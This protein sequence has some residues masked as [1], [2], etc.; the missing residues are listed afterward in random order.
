MAWTRSK[1]AIALYVDG[2]HKGYANKTSTATLYIP[3]ESGGGKL[4]MWD[5]SP[6]TVQVAFEKL[7]LPRLVFEQERQ[8]SLPSDPDRIPNWQCY[9][10]SDADFEFSIDT[11]Q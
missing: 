10:D 2:D 3:N 7:G 6:G 4:R 1:G 11:D 9:L 5:I 8:T